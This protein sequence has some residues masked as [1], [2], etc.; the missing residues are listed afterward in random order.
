MATHDKLLIFKNIC[1]KNDK[2]LKNQNYIQLQLIARHKTRQGALVVY[3]YLIKLLLLL[4][5]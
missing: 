2:K 5:M 3:V 1:N 4:S